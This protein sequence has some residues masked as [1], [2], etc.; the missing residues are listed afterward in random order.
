VAQNIDFNIQLSI[1][2]LS[3]TKF[4]KFRKRIDN[5]F[6]IKNEKE[7][8]MSMTSN[9][10]ALFYNVTEKLEDVDSQKYI[11]ED[12]RETLQ[13][14]VDVAS[15]VALG[16]EVTD[17]EVTNSHQF[18]DRFM[19]E[20]A[21]KKRFESHYGEFKINIIKHLDEM[22]KGMED[23]ATKSPWLL[24]DHSAIW[25]PMQTRFSNDK[26][27]IYESIEN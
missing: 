13:G 17:D 18:L 14:H 1:K 27:K 25:N 7:Q 2:T 8:L 15:K 3:D 10:E 26:K 23:L 6:K 12:N 9:L 22:Q 19:Q 24:V 20:I 16:D 5:I 21:Y 11:C 4:E